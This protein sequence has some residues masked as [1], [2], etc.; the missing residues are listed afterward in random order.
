MTRPRRAIQAGDNGSGD[1]G[2]DDE[3]D[4]DPTPA[5]DQVTVTLYFSDSQGQHVIPEQRNIRLQGEQTLEKAV[6]EQILAGPEDPDL[7]PVLPAAAELLSVDIADGIA[8]V[9]LSADARVGGSTAELIALHGLI[10]ALT[11]LAT[12]DALQILIEGQSNVS[13]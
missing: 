5:A 12:I 1:T 7:G 13:L 9:N 8:Y 10:Y 2:G 6:V 11:D 3:P 4:L